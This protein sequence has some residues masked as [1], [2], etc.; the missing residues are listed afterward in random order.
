M[1][2]TAPPTPVGLCDDQRFRVWILHCEPWQPSGPHDLPP[3]GIVLELAEPCC[4]SADEARD[5]V[6]GFNSAP[7][8]PPSLWAVSLPV[9]LR[10]DSEPRPGAIL[11][12][13]RRGQ[14][15]K[16]CVQ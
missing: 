11:H 14:P 8:R 10:L 6:D 12:H 2:L 1:R 9:R 5:Y 15:P 7:R 3:R 16:S 4:F 13:G